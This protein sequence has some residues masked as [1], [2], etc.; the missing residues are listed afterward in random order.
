MADARKG[1]SFPMTGKAFPDVAP[2]NLCPAC[3][4][5]WEW[6]A[7]PWSITKAHH[8]PSLPKLRAHLDLNPQSLGLGWLC[9]SPSICIVLGL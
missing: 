6:G 7:R 5:A 9:P 3:K 2:P 1:S 8:P 4:R